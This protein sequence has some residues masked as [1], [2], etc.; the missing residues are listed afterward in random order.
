MKTLVV[1]CDFCLQRLGE[2]NVKRFNGATDRATM[3]AHQPACPAWN[4]LAARLMK[5]EA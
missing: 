4:P 1:Y 2:V 5:L 3:L